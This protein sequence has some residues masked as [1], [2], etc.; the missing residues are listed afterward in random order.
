MMAFTAIH[1]PVGHESGRSSDRP[2]HLAPV[3]AFPLVQRSEQV[4]S[5]VRKI[6]VGPPIFRAKGQNREA[7]KLSRTVDRDV[8]ALD[9]ERRG[10]D[11]DTAAYV[12][13]PSTPP[14]AR[15]YCAC[16]RSERAR[17]Y[18]ERARRTIVE[19]VEWAGAAI[20]KTRAA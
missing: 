11:A 3:R 7:F 10:T 1:P 16:R 20:A 15:R 17:I 8:E 2:G 18:I 9:F 6:A 4:L 14:L 5:Q 19:T 12:A 13:L